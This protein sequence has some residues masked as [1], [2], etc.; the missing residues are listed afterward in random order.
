MYWQRRLPHWVPEDS[1]VLV[2]WRLAGSKR[3]PVPAA[4]ARWLGQARI[5]AIL[6]QALIHGETVRRSYDLLAWV[7]MPNHVHVV[8]QPI[9]PLSEI[10]RWLKAATANRANALLGRTGTA[11][12][13]REYFDRWIRSENQLAPVIAYVEDNPVRSGLAACS[14]EWPWSSAYKQKNTASKTAGA[15]GAADYSIR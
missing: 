7:I 13:Q 6:A 9:R 12:W 15:T 4:G 5:A 8:M 10:M 11:F 3:A 1:A 14:E 2:T